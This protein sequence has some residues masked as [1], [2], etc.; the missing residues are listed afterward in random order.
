M[1]QAIQFLVPA[2]AAITAIILLVAG[3][4]LLKPAIGLSGGLIGVGLGLLIAQKFSMNI[5]PLIIAAV[6]GII[7]ALI[8]VYIAKFAILILLAL[9]FA[10]LFPLATWHIAG[11]GDS[12]QTVKN[13][14]TAFTASTTEEETSSASTSSPLSVQHA[15]SDAVALFTNDALK[16]ARDMQQRAFAA[17][18]AIEIGSRFMLI[19]SAIAGLLLGLLVATFMPY[20]ATTAVTSVAGSMLL[21]EAIRSC[22]TLVWSQQTMS[23]LSPTVLVVSIVS[24][25]IA[26]FGLQL[27]LFRPRPQI[28]QIAE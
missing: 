9:S 26:G 24:I 4:R 19:G 7:A 3:G 12:T 6:C 16:L 17:F 27:T 10:L 8:A 5:S 23:T 11:L 13:I 22:I 15:F 18:E 25:A 20:V 1:D 21:V 28:K 2:I 14:A